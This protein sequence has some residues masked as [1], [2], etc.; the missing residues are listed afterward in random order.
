M[1][2]KKDNAVVTVVYGDIFR[3]IHAVTKPSQ[4]AYARRI[5]A[6]YVT[7]GSDGSQN[8][9]WP[10]D[11]SPQWIKLNLF[12]QL[13]EYER[14]IFLD[15]DVIVNAECPNL[16]DIVPVTHLGAFVEGNIAPRGDAL[17]RCLRDYNMQTARQFTGEYFNSGVMVLSAVHQGLFTWPEVTKDNYFEQ[18]LLNARAFCSYTPMFDLGY[19]YNRMSLCDTIT[20]EDRFASWIIHYAGHSYAI[21]KKEDGTVGEPLVL[22]IIRDDLKAWE[23]KRTPKTRIMIECRGG[24][25]DVVCAEPIL[26]HAI[27]KKYK[28]VPNVEFTILTHRARVFQH[29]AYPNVEVTKG[30][31]ITGNR[32]PTIELYMEKKFGATTPVCR[33]YTHPPADHVTRVYYPYGSVHNLDFGMITMLRDSM[34]PDEKQIDLMVTVDDLNELEVACPEFLNN[35]TVRE[36]YV[37]IHPGVGWESKTFPQAYWSEIIQ[38]LIDVGL[39]PVIFGLGIV[40]EL[41]ATHV[42]G[43]WDL[44][45]PKG[46]IDM[47]DKLTLGGMFALIQQ[48]PFLLSN[49]S[50]P[51]HIAGAFDNWIV[52]IA[53]TKRPE[54]VFPFRHGVV[55]YKTK[56][57]FKKLTCE[58]LGNLPTNPTQRSI[59]ELEGDIMEYLPDT[60]EV[61]GALV[62]CAARNISEIH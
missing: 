38:K 60:G 41:K 40:K 13:Q 30:E 55:S 7:M 57:V 47:R 9:P 45:I 1:K 3:Q 32:H 31:E 62:E 26:R 54:L 28:G 16:F 27:E 29:F 21:E 14:I 61:V 23:E 51:V 43:V 44:P 52:M 58:H 37:A 8:A 5:G 18:S 2:R 11:I 53:T 17:Q 6:K 24:L 12:Q 19:K 46:A 49:D 39:T 35:R 22:P 4:L 36:K 20:G 34:P 15:A 25:G 10:K 33:W 59:A 48:C 56:A 42:G 50:S